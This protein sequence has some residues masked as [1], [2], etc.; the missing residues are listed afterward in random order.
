MKSSNSTNTAATSHPYRL[1]TGSGTTGAIAGAGGAHTP[2]VWRSRLWATRRVRLLFTVCFLVAICFLFSASYTA[3]LIGVGLEESGMVVLLG[4]GSDQGVYSCRRKEHIFFMKTHKCASSSLQNVFFR[5][6]DKHNL[7]IALPLTNANYFGHP[8][9]FNRSMLQ[10]ETTH[11]RQPIVYSIF[12]SHTRFHHGEVR[13]VMPTDTIYIT[14][15]RD[16]VGLFGSMYSY[17]DLH[18]AYKLSLQD[19]VQHHP[20]PLD[21][22][23][24][25][26]RYNKFGLNQMAFDLGLPVNAFRN[27]VAVDQFI[28]RLEETFDLVLI[29]ERMSESLVLLRYLLCWDV[30]DVV[31]FKKNARSTLFKKSEEQLT[32]RDVNTLRTLNAADQRI[33]D[34]FNAKLTEKV[35][36]FGAQRMA[37]EKALLD[38]RSK[39]W[40]EECVEDVKKVDNEE[41]AKR[42][43][44]YSKKVMYF[45]EK[46]GADPECQ[47]MLR[48]E[49]AYIALLRE[50]QS[51][52]NYNLTKVT[53]NTLI[54]RHL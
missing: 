48:E 6:G 7:T 32:P 19:L 37:D 33:Y 5:Y 18:T 39:Y 22:I 15:L 13:K 17:Y 42:M 49:L 40:F 35:K 3:P 4:N 9:F 11:T 25:N 12:A 52:I 10:M 34:Y 29:A 16:P 45:E 38:T 2:S 21:P 30:D 26:R 31:L 46:D 50:K 44:I 27:T 43:H 54:K 8:A 36:R 20:D 28:Q 47:R 51:Y 24:R 23:H 53:G 1:L 14:I 41:T